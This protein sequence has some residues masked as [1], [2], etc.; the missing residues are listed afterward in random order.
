MAHLARVTT[1]GAIA[2]AL[3]AASCTTTGPQPT[4]AYN[5]TPSVVIEIPDAYAVFDGDLDAFLEKASSQEL[6]QAERDYLDSLSRV[7]LSSP[8]G[9]RYAALLAF[10]AKALTGSGTTVLFVTSGGPAIDW[11]SFPVDEWT[12]E[13]PL[14]GARSAE[15]ERV[16]VNDR[17]AML[18]R[19]FH[20]SAGF[21]TPPEG[22]WVTELS[23]N[24]GRSSYTIAATTENRPGR[25]FDDELLA[26]AE[27][28]RAADDE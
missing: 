1:H 4:T 13:G 19:Y 21:E 26:M 6:D 7:G 18:L 12:Q 23:F 22:A 25:A 10:R 20:P 15:A 8:E 16:T 2:L 9:A 27:S 28:L 24:S 14:A 5:L 11:S 3:I 17:P